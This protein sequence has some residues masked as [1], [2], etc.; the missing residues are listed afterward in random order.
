[1]VETLEQ[2]EEAMRKILRDIQKE[3]PFEDFSFE[4][5]RLLKECYD[6]GYFE[7]IA[8][9]EMISGRIVGEYRHQPR[10]TYKGMQFL[11]GGGSPQSP[12]LQEIA[13]ELKSMNDDMRQQH[14]E[15][16]TEKEID[17]RFQLIYTV[18]SAAIG[19]LVTL[20][21]EHF[22]GILSFIKGIFH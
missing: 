6:A 22:D 14:S 7:G 17:R 15:E 11:A 9:L 16:K 5:Q 8:I 12:D 19:S 2:R 18:V 4:E 10:L 1:M 21:V 13:L 20:F 3:R